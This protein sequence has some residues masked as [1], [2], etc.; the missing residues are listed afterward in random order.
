MPVKVRVWDLPT[1]FFH[2]LLVMCVVGLVATGQLGGAAMRWHFQFGYLMLSLLLFRLVWG[3]MGGHWS[4]FSSFLYSPATLWRFIRWQRTPE[5]SVGHNPLGALSVF[6]MLGVL[7]VQV[8]SGLMS[9]DEISN[10]GPLSQFVSSYLVNSATNYHKNF[11]KFLM[12][13]LVLLH[14]ATIFFYFFKR[15]EN[16]IQPMLTG[17]KLLS[18]P[19]PS[20]R[21]D[22]RSRSMAL[23]L[24]ASSVG[25]V[26]GL[27]YFFA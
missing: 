23:L 26:Q 12:I 24:F 13:G 7:L 21:D 5:Q 18:V 25:L 3:C 1:R 10:A 6:A 4:R 17:D 16:L 27:V 15:K 14:V 19:M 8:A 11:G 22:T 9:D 2:W 20:A